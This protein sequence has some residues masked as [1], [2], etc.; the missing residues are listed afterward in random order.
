MIKIRSQIEKNQPFVGEEIGD[1][2]E[3]PFFDPSG[4]SLMRAPL[5]Q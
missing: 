2:E 5:E 3:V 4:S 1:F